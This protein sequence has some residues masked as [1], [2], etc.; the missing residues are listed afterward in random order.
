LK[1][2][3]FLHV[4]LCYL[5]VTNEV[6]ARAAAEQEVTNYSDKVEVDS[7]LLELQARLAITLAE[8]EKVQLQATSAT[9]E[10]EC[11]KIQLAAASCN[12][13]ELTKNDETSE[14]IV[15]RLRQ[16]CQELKEELEVSAINTASAMSKMTDLARELDC[17]QIELHRVK[18]AEESLKLENDNLKLQAELWKSGMERSKF[19]AES[20]FMELER[21]KLDSE[22]DRTIAADESQSELLI[23][24]KLSEERAQWDLEV[25]TSTAYMSVI[26]IIDRARTIYI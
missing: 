7:G 2:I 13:S 20:L 4:T 1:Y 24:A 21:S 6:T 9:A 25:C 11:L 19:E 16:E 3:S 12:S 8:L 22:F 17:V 15:Q 10:V 5:Q 18:M 14:T 26:M 23:T